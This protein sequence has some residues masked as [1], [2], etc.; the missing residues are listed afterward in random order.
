[1][2]SKLI[3]I[4]V[5]MC[6]ASWK[7]RLGININYIFSKF[8]YGVQQF[9]EYTKYRTKINPTSKI[10]TYNKQIQTITTHRTHHK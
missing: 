1:M 6:C 7:I 10:S 5:Y 2:T 9:K 3:V 8:F 4:F